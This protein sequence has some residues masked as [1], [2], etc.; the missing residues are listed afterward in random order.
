MN[1]HPSRKAM[2]AGCGH[3]TMPA[4]NKQF[5]H[6]ILGKVKSF[7]PYSLRE[8]GDEYILTMPLPGHDASN[9]EV[10]VKGTSILIEAHPP[11]VMKDSDALEDLEDVKIVTSMMEFLWNKPDVEVQIPVM[12]TINPE[13]VKARLSKGILTVIFKKEPSTRVSVAE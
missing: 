1:H 13:T 10:S 8:T 3:F 4:I 12:D 2:P 5:I 11:D 6:S 9:I 7:M